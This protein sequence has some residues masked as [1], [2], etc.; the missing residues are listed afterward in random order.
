M[1]EAVYPERMNYEHQ[2]N[3]RTLLK[4]NETGITPTMTLREGLVLNRNCMIASTYRRANKYPVIDC[5]LF[6]DP[7]SDTT[8]NK[9]ISL[10]S[11]SKN[12]KKGLAEDDIYS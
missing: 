4:I 3:E 5:D 12:P 11:N 6:I 9:S 8:E 10:K 2:G 1:I 7:D